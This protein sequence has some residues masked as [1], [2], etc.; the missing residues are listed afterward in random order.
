M[1]GEDVGVLDALGID[2]LMR[3]DMRQCRQAVAEARRALVVLLQ[4][5]LVHEL[6]QAPLHLVA[7][8]G[9][10]A[11]RLVDECGVFPSVTSPVQGALQRLI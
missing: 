9:E 10:E 1:G 5:R 6:V 2:A 4:A 7:L 3:L 8:A 11:E